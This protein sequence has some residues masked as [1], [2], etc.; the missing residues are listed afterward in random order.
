MRRETIHGVPCHFLM[1]WC[2]GWPQGRAGVELEDFLRTFQSKDHLGITGSCVCYCSTCSL[3]VAMLHRSSTLIG[4]IILH[5]ATGSTDCCPPVN[6][7]K[8]TAERLKWKGR[9]LPNLWESMSFWW[10]VPCYMLRSPAFWSNRKY[11]AKQWINKGCQKLVNLQ[12]GFSTSQV[13]RFHLKTETSFIM[14]WQAWFNKNN[15]M[16]LHVGQSPNAG[17]KCVG[18]LSW[19]GVTLMHCLFGSDVE[20]TRLW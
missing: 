11:L 6:S 7:V 17:I 15:V 12:V 8:G 3:L 10:N 16:N 2:S 9:Y 20:T 4:W 14:W 1:S 18:F 5:S 19:M 13:L